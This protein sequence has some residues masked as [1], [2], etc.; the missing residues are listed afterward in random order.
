MNVSAVSFNTSKP[1]SSAK[2]TQTTNNSAPLKSSVPSFSQAKLGKLSESEIK[3]LYMDGKELAQM[4][5]EIMPV[6]EKKFNGFFDAVLNII[7]DVDRSV[8]LNIKAN[9]GKEAE[10]KKYIVKNNTKFAFPKQMIADFEGSG[11]AG[12]D[13]WLREDAYTPIVTSLDEAGSVSN[14]KKI[15]TEFTQKTNNDKL[16]SDIFHMRKREFQLANKKSVPSYY[17]EYPGG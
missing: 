14:L 10:L 13:Y 12:F 8:T 1:V 15:I 4:V 2:N 3:A 7:P 9:L 17:W 11:R 6:L 16:I 5:K